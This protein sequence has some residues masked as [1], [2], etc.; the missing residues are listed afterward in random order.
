MGLT[1]TFLDAFPSAFLGVPDESTALSVL[2]SHRLI[3]RGEGRK[4]VELALWS[5]LLA[6][7][8]SM[9]LWPLY[10]ALASLYTPQL[11]RY[12]VVL[13]GIVLMASQAKKA[14]KAVLV[15]LLSGTLGVIALN[16][17]ALNEPYYHL[18]TG[19]FGIPVLISASKSGLPPQKKDETMPIS[20]LTLPVLVGS[21]LGMCASL[22]PSLT[23]SIAATLVSPLIKGDEEFLSVIYSTNTANFLFGVFNYSLTGRTRNGVVVAM[24]NSGAVPPKFAVIALS[25]LLVGSMVVLVG[26]F[27]GDLFLKFVKHVNYTILN[28]AVLVALLALSWR[29]DG[30]IGVWV[31]LTA[32]GIGYLPIL[33]GIRRTNCMGVLMVPIILM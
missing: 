12:G 6:L 32:A 24:A 8:V 18:F 17:L 5:S 4:V 9:F 3:L 7:V 31:M 30:F 26:I 19:L 13:I 23:P 20:S 21:L 25:A 29:F 10:T 33:L 11:G 1:H 15:F 22:M 27:L 14:P 2:P 16:K 28:A